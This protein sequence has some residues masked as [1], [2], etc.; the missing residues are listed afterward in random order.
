MTRRRSNLPA[1]TRTVLD[2]FISNRK[3]AIDTLLTHL[4]A[5]CADYFCKSPDEVTRFDAAGFTNLPERL[6][7]VVVKCG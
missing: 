6:N 1:D 7:E 5:A 4:T 3:S 2:M